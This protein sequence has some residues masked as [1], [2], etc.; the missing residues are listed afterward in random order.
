MRLTSIV[1]TTLPKSKNQ[2]DRQVAGGEEADD[3]DEHLGHLLAGRQ[4]G[5]GVASV[6]SVLIHTACDR[7][8]VS[9]G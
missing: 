3:G 7:A 8:R 5:F 4:L 1:Y 6:L 9:N 2:V